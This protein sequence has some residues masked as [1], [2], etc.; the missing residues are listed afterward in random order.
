MAYPTIKYNSSTGSNTDPSDCVASSVGTGVTASG[1]TTSAN[2][3]TFSSAVDLSNCDQD[4]S[5][6]I[7]CSTVSNDRHMFQ[8]TAFSP[9]AGACTSVTIFSA[10]GLEADFT[11]ASWHVNGTR[12]SFDQDP[13]HGDEQDWHRGWTIELDGTFVLADHFEVARNDNGTTAVDDDILTIKASPSASSKPIIRQ[14]NAQYLY[15]G[16]TRIV[17]KFQGIRLESTHDSA[18]GFIYL[19]LS[20]V[21]FVGCDIIKTTA[22]QPTALI[23]CLN[24]SIRLHDCYIKGGGTTVVDAPT[25]GHVIIDNCHF[26]CD[27]TYGTTQAVFLGG[28]NNVVTNTLVTKAVGD[29]ITMDMGGGAGQK[30]FCFFKNNTVADCG[31]DGISVIGTPSASVDPEHAFVFI[32]SLFVGNGGYGIDLTSAPVQNT[33]GQIDYN[34]LFN[35][36]SGGYGGISAGANDVTISADPFTSASTGDYSLNSSASGGELLKDA[37]LYTLP[38]GS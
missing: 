28:T 2:T 30:F 19:E 27:G 21:T 14:P 22:T 4:G 18:N 15:H 1:A 5:D 16:R 17:A 26:D 3:I 23:S 34:C 8:I 7:R 36:T 6:Y 25:T 38:T 12:Q 32:N 10:S 31:G 24:N 33:S 29:G 9:S 35:N 11:G 37:A 13:P 20:T